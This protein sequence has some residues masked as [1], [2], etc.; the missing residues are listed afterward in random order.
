MIP[1]I[2]FF[3]HAGSISAGVRSCQYPG[4]FVLGYYRDRP[5]TTTNGDGYTSASGNHS[6]T[7]DFQNTWAWSGTGFNLPSNDG[8]LHF[9]A[10]LFDFDSFMCAIGISFEGDTPPSYTVATNGSN[11]G[12]GPSG[13]HAGAGPC[14]VSNGTYSIS[15]TVDPSNAPSYWTAILYQFNATNPGEAPLLIAILS[16]QNGFDFDTV[17]GWT[18]LYTGSGGGAKVQIHYFT[19]LT[20]FSSDVVTDICERAG[21]D[22]SQIDVS[23]L[24]DA[25]IQP[26]TK[27][28][29]YLIEQP[30]PAAEILKVLMQAFFFDGCESGGKVRWIPRGLASAISIPEADL[31]LKSD[32]GK[33]EETLAQ[34]Q[35]LPQQI[36]VM[37]ND[38]VL[39]Y[40]QNKQMK[41]RNVRVI[42][43]TGQNITLSIPMTISANQAR[44]IAEKALYL[45]WLERS[46][47]K[48]NLWRALYMMLD[49]S[50]VIT[51]TYEG[52][53]FKARVTSNTLGQGFTVALECV[54]DN[55][56]NYL[57]SAQGGAIQNYQT[58]TT[59]NVSPTLL[60]LMDIPLVVD[61]DANP[62][63]SGFYFG[64]GNVSPNW[65]GATLFQSA[66]NSTFTDSVGS[67][68]TPATFG[69]ATTT[70]GAPATP[71]E[72]DTTNTLTVAL[73]SGALAGDTALNVLNGTNRALIGGEIVAFQT[74]V[75]NM[76]GT[77]TISNLLRGLRGTE[78]ACGTHAANESF[79]L[80]TTAERVDEP[81]AI[82]GQSLY[83]KL[84]TTGQDV[85]TA[86]SQSLTPSGADL[87]PYAPCQIG[88]TADG[89]GNITITWTR[90]TRIGGEADWA[91]GVGQV[92]V[93]E[94][95]ELYDVEILN[96]STVVRTF[97]NV[98]APTVI[99]T[100]AEQTADFGST[101]SSVNANVYQISGQV[102]RGAKGTG[103]APTPG[104]WPLP[105]P[106][107]SSGVGQFYVN[108]S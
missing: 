74:A 4:G 64:A 77:W 21:L 103:T 92:P 6:L 41:I 1:Q 79:V 2:T 94:D 97:S 96:G 61:T 34:A 69:T 75:Q 26:N 12:S 13:D 45:A 68:A 14:T 51:F 7:T 80:L 44:Q 88:G 49:P 62:S 35:D 43:A 65:T 57:S 20:T 106:A 63:G 19:G 72:W 37:H 108:G 10:E 46:S 52:L 54:S 28:A 33:I 55:V 107:S 104:G 53:T 87:K 50:D 78:A 23:L 56:D 25:N 22:S 17:P 5:P 86:T 83:F 18:P 31:G 60:L 73:S 48:I 42:G 93:S 82:V 47:Y 100:A 98:P 58:T 91:D 15:Q 85:S 36:T 59:S 101:Q 67:A 16:S 76:D 3:D 99:Y 95:A 84:V 8:L 66:D 27:V 71:W 11:N 40:Q 32:E 30:R 89:P 70:L 39:D 81:V 24:T 102:G 9:N 29:G 105:I 38:P 90:R